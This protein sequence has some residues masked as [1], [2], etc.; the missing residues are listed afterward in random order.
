MRFLFTV[1]ILLFTITISTAQRQEFLP[2]ID[3]GLNGGISFAEYEGYKGKLKVGGLSLMANTGFSRHILELDL[4]NGLNEIG[5]E[6]N[7]TTRDTPRSLRP[8]IFSLNYTFAREV[9]AYYPACMIRN[10]V[11]IGLRL[12]AEI[13]MGNTLVTGNSIY[14][15]YAQDHGRYSADLTLVTDYHLNKSNYLV[16]Q[17]YT[18]ILTY[19]A[20]PQGLE[21]TA[22]RPFEFDDRMDLSKSYFFN[23]GELGWIG[24]NS[25]L[26]INA[27]YRLL[28]AKNVALQL[29]YNG[30][31]NSRSRIDMV[32]NLPSVVEIEENYHQLTLGIVGHIIRPP[33]GF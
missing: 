29:K 21:P 14:N 25:K 1:L 30:R 33:I 32:G 18:P 24:K 5:L 27:T 19:F 20:Y 9:F 3:I 16:L 26:G 4:G 8:S 10:Q 6:Y 11:L 15:H 13:F 12:N 28:L 31:L 2:T 23:D 22:D 7:M 17:L